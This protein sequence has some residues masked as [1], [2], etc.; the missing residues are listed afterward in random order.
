MGNSVAALALREVLDAAPCGAVIVEAGRI[1]WANRRWAAWCGGEP[2]ALVGLDWTA[3]PVAAWFGA[4]TEGTLETVAGAIHW[5]R[6]QTPL[7]AGGTA[8]FFE[9]MGAEARLAQERDQY[10]ALAQSL[11][12][13]DPATGVLNLRAILQALENQMGRS[14]RYGNPLAAILLR[15]LPPDGEPDPEALKRVAQE[16][17]AELRWADQIGRFDANSFLVV[18]PETR[19]AA[20]EALAAKLGAERAARVRAGGGSIAVSATDWRT[21][22]DARKLLRRLLPTPP[23]R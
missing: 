14:R 2:V 6:T 3:P 21:G 8:Y 10:R 23:Q 22:D 11:E 18:L 5:R 1:A 20:A 12:T 19:L 13:R 9:D 15:V 4:A 17:N 7:A 16:L